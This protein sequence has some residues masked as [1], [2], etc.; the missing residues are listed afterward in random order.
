MK[1]L[2][3]DASNQVNDGTPNV[4]EGEV[5]TAIGVTIT[6]T[7]FILKE[8]DRGNDCLNVQ[9]GIRTTGGYSKRRFVPISNIDEK[10]LIKEREL[11]TE[12]V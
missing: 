4:I 6:D 8:L 11:L 9:L 12:K 10:E 7:S 1:V 5:Y 3:I 2:C